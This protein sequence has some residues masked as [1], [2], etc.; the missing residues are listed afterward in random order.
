MKR[1]ILTG[2]PGAG[3]TTILRAL[4]RRG[5]R[6]IEEAATDVVALGQ[7]LGN[8]EPWSSARFIDDIVNLQR[9]RQQAAA[10]S[11]P[12]QI[13]D[14]SPVCTLAL[15]RHLGFEATR[16]LAQELERIERDGV[17]ERRVFYVESLRFMTN[18][19][20]RRITLADALK[21]G[22]IHETAYRE[23]GYEL[24]RIPAGPLEQRVDQIVQPLE[25]GLRAGTS[26][27][28]AGR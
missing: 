4:E 13:F 16:P 7:M 10:R 14:R 26:E 8:P 9:R 1:Y 6:V 18:T 25:A 15:A 24:V 5:Y 17:Y 12:I 3:K 2:P 20:V 21:F 27:A 11:G 19:E 22:E 28:D 23:L